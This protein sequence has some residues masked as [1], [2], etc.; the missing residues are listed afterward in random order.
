MAL[1]PCVRQILCS[2]SG[3]VLRSLNAIINTQIGVLQAQV[4]V[5]E[6]QL[7]QYDILAIPVQAAANVA[8]ET[9]TEVRNSALL[10][11]LELIEDCLDLGLFNLN[12]Q[13]SIDVVIAELDNLVGNL[14]RL[15]SFREELAAIIAELNGIIDQFQ[16]ILA[17]IETCGLL[18]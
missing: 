11:P 10:I 8:R 15:L 1:N 7:L 13:R 6:A 3:T 4:L 14:T 5:F 18:T 16:D 17:T 2:L 9:L 12:L